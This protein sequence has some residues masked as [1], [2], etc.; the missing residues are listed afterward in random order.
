MLNDIR[1]TEVFVR[2][3]RSAEALNTLC[4]PQRAW[5][6]DPF[7]AMDRKKSNGSR[8]LVLFFASMAY[9]S[10]LLFISPLSSA[11]LAPVEIQITES[12]VFRAAALDEDF[13]WQLDLEDLIMFRTISGAILNTSTSAW[14]ADGFT[15]LPVWPSNY[16][17]APLGS[18]F[19]SNL[20]PQR[21]S[22]PS[23]VHKAEL[24]CEAMTTTNISYV[25]VNHTFSQQGFPDSTLVV[26]ETVIQLDSQDGCYITLSGIA[27]GTRSSPWVGKGGGWWS[28]PPDYNSSISQRLSN[29]SGTCGNRT[30]FFIDTGNQSHQ[31]NQV[32]AH[33]CATSFYAGVATITVSL[34]QTSTTVNFDKDEYIENAKQLDSQKYKLAQLVNAFISPHWQS[35]FMQ[36]EFAGPLLALASSPD[37]NSDPT[38]MVNSTSLLDRGSNLFQHFF[39]EMLLMTL[40]QNSQLNIS[41]S[42]SQ[43]R[44]N[45]VMGERSITE[46]RIVASPGIGI[47]IGLLIMVSTCCI[48]VVTYYSRVC[49]RPLNLLEDPGTIAAAASSICADANARAIFEG[50]DQLPT[51]AL[52]SRLK[53]SM[54]SIDRGSLVLMD[55]G[56]KVAQDSRTFVPRASSTLARSNDQTLIEATSRRKDP[57]AAV[58]RS[59]IGLL[60]SIAL[61]ILLVSLVVLYSM[62]RADGLYQSA[63][64]YQLNFSVGNFAP[65]S[66]FPTLLAV[67]VKLWFGAIGDTLKRLEP[68]VSMTQKPAALSRSVLVE[69]VNTPIAIATF[70]AVK[71]SHWALALVGLGA[72]ATEAFTV[73]ISALWDREIRTVDRLYNVSRQFEPRYVPRIFEQSTYSP[74]SPPVPDPKRT[75]LLKTVYQTSSL[76]SW[77][78]GAAIEV[79]QSGPTPLW[80]KDTWSFVPL[81]LQDL[82]SQVLQEVQ[83]IKAGQNFNISVE[84]PALRARLQCSPLDYSNTSLWLTRLDFS[85]QTMWNDSNK[86][87]GLNHGYTLKGSAAR[88]D[89]LANI[90]GGGI[91]RVKCCANETKSGFG[92][93]AV[94]YWSNLIYPP[95]GPNHSSSFTVLELSP[96]YKMTMTA[97]WIVGRPLKNLYAPTLRDPVSQDDHYYV[98][99]DEP[100]F[101]GINCTPIIEQANARVTIDAGTG[102]VQRYEILD[103]PRNASNAWSDPYL[104]HDTSVD[105]TG[106]FEDYSFIGKQSIVHNITVRYEHTIKRL[107]N[108]DANSYGNVFWDALMN[109]GR[110]TDEFLPAQV[111]GGFESLEDDLF[112]FRT[113][114][115]NADFMSYLGAWELSNVKGDYYENPVF[116]VSQEMIWDPAANQGALAFQNNTTLV[117]RTATA[118][119]HIPV[120]QLVMSK[121]AVYLCISLLA[122]LI[123]VVAVIYT[124]N[125]DR[126]K[127]LPRDV[128]TLASTLAYVHNS[129]RLLHWVQQESPVALPWYR[130]FFSGNPNPDGGNLMARLGPFVSPDGQQRWG[131]ELVDLTNTGDE[132]VL[133]LMDEAVELQSLTDSRRDGQGDIGLQTPHL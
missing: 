83:L 41:P 38:S 3:S 48:V 34:N 33:L 126:V 115:L 125:R 10:V 55:S 15:I 103:I 13:R 46:R 66:V 68:Y 26:N 93:A 128:D 92:E 104:E 65:Y 77:L 85:N 109:S 43:L 67:L 23:V 78:Y 112:S 45:A 108:A 62:S 20:T 133:G 36:T 105:Y 59:S 40:Q 70:K 39:G 100:K 28:G 25:T 127:A 102:N 1:R 61:V 97:K 32:R 107:L 76:Q 60:F 57:R 27:T 5:W 118:V 79:S 123:S 101:T 17:N 75:T 121:T 2:L 129:E 56:R 12:I 89:G 90:G 80:S 4:Y 69:Y 94:G 49:R 37:Y 44:T 50:S 30:M 110:V 120:E 64:V 71:H 73:G 51:E 113:R 29:S 124:F 81:D 8:S 99:I 16:L 130:A 72:L 19:P 74:D 88:R 11:F 96:T 119:L 22:A 131:I 111:V 132:S 24:L 117:S 18:V 7:D 58:L 87:E 106:R 116:N 84:T 95:I 91:S 35:L 82:H 6:N 53:N 14:L 86:P 9:V 52:I 21:W 122:F 31:P 47:A 63:F 98:W 114:G 54:F 42:G